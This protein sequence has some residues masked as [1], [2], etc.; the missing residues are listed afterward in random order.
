MQARASRLVISAMHPGW[1]DTR[2]VREALPRFHRLTRWF[3]RDA[4]QG[5]DTA[6]W[7]AAAE[8]AAD[9]G[10]KLFLDRAPRAEHVPLAMTQTP[11]DDVDALWA[12]C[13]RLGGVAWPS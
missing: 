4:A 2:G 10:G 9:A 6:V 1:A 5:A 7:L 11:E 3:L 12:L 13:E 8:A